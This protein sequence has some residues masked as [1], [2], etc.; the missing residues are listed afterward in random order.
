[1]TLAVCAV[2]AVIAAVLARG[3]GSPVPAMVQDF[4]AEAAVHVSGA[5]RPQETEPVARVGAVQPADGP[6]AT[7][8]VAPA[9]EPAQADAGREPDRPAALPERPDAAADESQTVASVPDRHRRHG[10]SGWRRAAVAAPTVRRTRLDAARSAPANPQLACNSDL[11]MAPELCTAFRCATAE[12]RQHPVCV[13]MHA[14]GALARARL[15]ESRG[16][17]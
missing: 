4:H 6:K 11:S 3:A 9:P 7:A 1:V 12:F 16:G 2:V 17:P 5:G 14:E 13:R 8:L 10:S 15:A